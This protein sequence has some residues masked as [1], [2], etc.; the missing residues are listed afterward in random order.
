MNTAETI[1]PRILAVVQL[2]VSLVVFTRLP[3]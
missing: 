3:A 1:L 2:F